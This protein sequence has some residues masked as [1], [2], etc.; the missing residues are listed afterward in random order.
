MSPPIPHTPPSERRRYRWRRPLRGLTVGILVAVAV[1][2][3]A[4]AS[5]ASSPPT[6]LYDQNNNTP[7]LG[8]K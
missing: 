1:G 2:L 4:A 7:D 6:T 3:L 8:T 5:A